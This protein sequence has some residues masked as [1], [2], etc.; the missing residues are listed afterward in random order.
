MSLVAILYD[1]QLEHKIQV[2]TGGEFYGVR[3]SKPKQY[4]LQDH[5]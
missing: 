2:T 4:E 5:C 3:K 1:T